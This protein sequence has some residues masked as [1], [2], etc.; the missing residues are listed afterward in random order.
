MAYFSYADPESVKKIIKGNVDGWREELLI[1]TLHNA[2][3]R[4]NGYF[5]TLKPIW[6]EEED[7]SAIKE[8]VIAMVA[9]AARKAVINPDGISSETMGP[10]AYSKFDSEDA[11]KG[12]FAKEDMA[13][14]AALLEAAGDS[15]ITGINLRPAMLPAAPMPR[16]G[17]Y[18]N[19]R[20][21]RRY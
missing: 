19:S 1:Q 4:L 10:Y 6:L 7:G 11:A 8:L 15:Q 14:L 3:A 5:P 17:K 18:T 16:P 20:R 13:A 2:S 21:W 9:E 12:W